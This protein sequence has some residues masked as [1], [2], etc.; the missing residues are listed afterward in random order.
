M[1]GAWR[2]SC[3][4]L[5]ISCCRL[6]I[7]VLAVVMLAASL[8]GASNS[9]AVDTA[10]PV[11]GAAAVDGDE[12]VLT[13]D[14]ALDA[15]SV[16]AGEAFTVVVVD[17]V[18]SVS[19]T[20][21]VTGVDVAAAAVTLTL[22][23][24]VRHGDAVTV[25]YRVPAGARAEPISD[26][27]GNE[28]DAIA[29]SPTVTNNTAKA[30][31]AALGAL[32]V[33]PGS[34]DFAAATVAYAVAVGD[35]VAAVTVTAAASDRRAAVAF[36]LGGNAQ[37]DGVDIPVEAGPNVITVTVTAED[38][39]TTRTYTLTVT[40]GAAPVV[41]ISAAD[42]TVVEGADA[43]LEV[44]LTAQPTDTVTVNLSGA[45]GTD[46]TVTGFPMM[47]TAADWDTAQG[48]TVAAGEDDDAVDDTVTLTLT[49]TGA[50]EYAE[51]STDVDVTVVDDD[52]T[53]D[54]SLSALA[55]SGMVLSP[56]FDPAV[57][58]YR[59]VFG[60]GV[61]S[62]A[63]TATAA[64]P[65]A[66]VVVELGGEVAADGTV[67]LA[68]GA[69]VVTVTVTAS[70]RSTTKV[71]TVT[72]T[73]AA[74]DDATLSALSLSG[75]TLPPPFVSPFDSETTSGVTLSPPFDPAVVSYSAAVGAGVSSTVV[76]A[77]AAHDDATVVVKLG[78]VVA[79]DGT[80]DL[81]LGD[82]TVT[83]TVTASDRSTTKV[84]T[85][86]ATRG[87]VLTDDDA[88]ISAADVT[89]VEGADA[90][91]EVKLTVQPTDTVT[92]NLSGAAGTDLTVTGFPMMFT[93]ADWDTAQSATVA[94]G[95]DDDAVDDTVTL[96]LTATGAA[97]YAEVSTDVDVTVADDDT[98]DDASLSALALS[99]MVLSPGFDPAVVSYRAVFGAGVTSTAVTAT[100][101][102][103]YATVVVELGGEVAADGTVDLALGANVV[104]VTVTAS[105]R[106][107]TK[108]YTVTATHAAA[109]DATLSALSLS[110]VTLP[111]PFVSPF[112]SE[113]TSGVTLSPPFDP[114]V[115]SYSAAV[116][117]GVSSTVVAAD[118]AHDD[119]TVV[120]KLGGVVAADGTVDLALGDNTVTV[121]VTASD[122]STTKVYTVT[123]TRG[124]VLTDD[125]AA[126]SAADVTVVE[127]ADA[128]LEVKLTVQ[129]TDTVT[130]NLSGAAGTDLTVTGFPMM[131]TAADWDTA[132]SATVAAGEDDDTVDDTVTLTLTATG[133]AEYA[134]VST[135][136]DVTV[137]DD[138]TTDDASLSAL[139]L[140]GMVLSP[141]F[142][143]A[144]VSY[145]AVFGAGVTSTAVT[146]TAADPYATV[147][148]ELGGEVA[149]D[150]TVDLALGANVVTVTVTA[151]DR[152]TT[153]V[154]TV[155]ATHAAADDA[156]LSALSLSGVTLPPPFDSETTSGV[157]LSPPFDPAVV[158]YSAAVGAGV[159]STV[160]A[161]DAAH[162]DATVVVKLG[163]VVAADGTVDLALGDNTVTVTVTASDR[164]TTKVYTVTATRGVVLTDDDAAISAADVTV[165]E[166]AD[167]QLEVKLTAQPTDTVTVNLSGAAGT[168][169]TVTGFPMMFTAADWDTAQSATV[170]A[171]EDDD[172]VDDTVTLT[173]TATGA[174][175]YAEVST[176][177]DVTV[178]DDDGTTGLWYLDD[179]SGSVAVDSVGS[180]NGV[181]GGGAS[182][183]GD[184]LIGGAVELDGSDDHVDIGAAVVDTTK[185]Y[186]V[187]AYVRLD[188]S[189]GTQ[190]VLSQDGNRS[191]GFFLQVH[192]GKWVFAV[193]SAD[194]D[195]F[196]ISR[197]S[198]SSVVL[199]GVWTHL[200][201]VHDGE[202]DEL[203]LYVNGEQDGTAAFASPWSAAGSLVFGRGKYQGGSV[204]F[205][206]GR[207]DEVRTYDRALASNEIAELYDQNPVPDQ[208]LVYLMAYFTGNSGILERMYYAYSV[209]GLAWN[210]INGA[211][212]VF[213]AYDDTVRIRDPYMLKVNGKFHLVHTAGRDNKYVFHWES[214]DGIT[215]SGAN[216]QRNRAAGQINVVP[217]GN[218]APNAWAPEFYWDGEK[219]YLFWTSK[220]WDLDG[221]GR[222]TGDE[223]RQKLFYV[224]TTDWLSF[225]EPR[226]LFD[227]GFGAIDLNVISE[228]GTVY[229]IAKAEVGVNAD[230]Y[231]FLAKGDSITSLSGVEDILPTVRGV[232]GPQFLKLIDGSFR[233]Y[234]DFF[235]IGSRSWGAAESDDLETWT[236]IT[237]DP[238][239]PDD[240]RHGSIVIVTKQEVAAILEEYNTAVPSGWDD[241]PDV[242]VSYGAATYDVD[243]GSSVTV[244]VELSTAP[245]RWVTVPVTLGGTATN[246]ADYSG[247]P[248]YVTF[249]AAQTTA[250][251][252]L[253][254]ADNTEYTDDETV[255]FGF[256]AL[257]DGFTA[258][259]RPTTTVTIIDDDDVPTGLWRLDDGSGS[260]AVDSVGS[261][262][263]VL[264]GGASFTGDGLFGGAVELDGS[265]DHVDIG[266]AVVDT[267]KS[268]T[269]SAYVR[270]DS[271][272]GTQ[273]VLSQDGNR[274]SGFF[275]QN[276][277]G[278]WAFTVPS[279]DLDSFG[280]ARASSSSV[281]L[282]G[283]WTHLVGVH[284]G[285][286]DELRLYVNGEQAGTATFAS[287]WSAAGSLVFG[288]GKY[289]GRSVDFLDGRI[290]EVR[291][292]G[293][294]LTS[295]EIAELYD[296][297]PV[298][299][300]DLV[301]LMAYFIGNSGIQQKVYYAYSVDAL[302][303]NNINGARPV[304]DAYDDT[305]NIRDPYMLKVN[306]KFHLVHT[307]GWDNKYVF[308][309]ES[310]DG[311][312]WSGANGQR[313]R[314]AGQI[315]VVPDGNP[316]PNAWAPEFYWD[317]EKFYLFWSSKHWDLNGDG[318]ATGDE[319]RFKLFYVT[320]TD[321]LTFS[322][323]QLLFDPGFSRHRPQRHLRG[324]HGVR[325]YQVRGR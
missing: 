67:D 269:V 170:A 175:E 221:D 176:D 223:Q 35:G 47:F 101:A 89:V 27:H 39:S 111:P 147:V 65:Y 189:S 38:G 58:S 314:A 69:N 264:V 198:S 275:L 268:Y 258:G 44:K 104:T 323:P 96:T 155:T 98:T 50:A 199:A 64:D 112:D 12:L 8:A 72:A 131:F 66:T 302:A 315:N 322:A 278:R 243:E 201:G 319:G 167:A 6:A 83:V 191:S 277:D 212:P 242:T 30:A 307:A 288:R 19:S 180:N 255:G 290:D 25:T 142:D 21:A 294:A 286:A 259:V 153:K 274:V 309:W 99:G 232:K 217:D 5:A 86:T 209:D 164:S 124:V 206:D 190:T 192:D 171:G 256:G 149:A 128:Q 254:A 248:A 156:T 88:A 132:Q 263:G 84:Y 90:Q 296:E 106:S 179:G 207:I 247:V 54:A 233:L 24:A 271:S 304:F 53:D 126:I 3:R 120:V 134:E 141:G 166:G 211:R 92:V 136:V 174:A 125:D 253:A 114:A 169:L 127:G 283:V 251:I 257:P 23:A 173:L 295:N 301:Y 103:P 97:E 55:L 325:H 168:D 74:A 260:V 56:G 216:G 187:S 122:R 152:S 115:V 52:T 42:V 300:Q 82:N 163:G 22:G 32:G 305:V 41:A 70:D 123:A 73:H 213:D 2:G 151:S 219:F 119:A 63:V 272:S 215:W 280:T 60:A 312:T 40:V 196:D 208:D 1:M 320:T 20:P 261:N 45:A 75:V 239:F 162:D 293:R 240:V 205:L 316:A 237:P 317:G 218:P 311:I 234:Y 77:D 224:T 252:I 165:V 159:S 57:V 299:D 262:N 105:D 203:R 292:Y 117:A 17:S 273:T 9:F 109:D 76:A 130:V 161:A 11:L 71:Y 310:N 16:P 78:G 238:I 178:A 183:P 68:L 318:Q 250:T 226:L 236:E 34:I 13:F 231:L 291:T 80:V 81:A 321:W 36:A 95:E 220:H 118:A 138:D 148:V 244:T 43:Q 193:P 37:S 150:G 28:A 188:S 246:N 172:T 116:G 139:A 229:G 160:V 51:V 200:V 137:V 108:V 182:F 276:Y 110:G 87:V 297:N 143:P 94:A 107:T 279:G 59:A 157:T 214:N 285:E 140:S 91:L 144:V 230:R 313:N 197:A 210:N 177:V 154:Y 284:D 204:D 121:T 227:P 100:A 228:G 14:E 222:A 10:A 282:A 266:A 235:T 79:A 158:S 26:V 245:K 129:P 270:L 306:G 113:T 102:D 49:A 15:G 61:T 202:A 281:V 7:A 62:T 298:P 265:D 184:G 93:A 186:T 48:A 33:T 46:L 18:S 287:P 267:T 308:H 146:A 241:V 249:S 185:S 303:W 85:V 31:D 181:L 225:S 145:R 135:D 195:S 4:R 289:Q 194:S 29:E 324:R 133:A